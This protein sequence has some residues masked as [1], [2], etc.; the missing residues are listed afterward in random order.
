[1]VT[2]SRLE[3]PTARKHLMNSHD[4]C[5]LSE[6]GNEIPALFDEGAYE[7]H[8][9]TLNKR[10]SDILNKRHINAFLLH[11]DADKW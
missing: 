1:M 7:T 3:S 6:K 5:K 2:T 9:L 10:R 11:T 8:A 4:T